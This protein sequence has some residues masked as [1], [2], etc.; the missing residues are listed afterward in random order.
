MLPY[1][2]RYKDSLPAIWRSNGVYQF[3]CGC[4]IGSYKKVKGKGIWKGFHSTKL[5]QQQQE[6]LSLSKTVKDHMLICDTQVAW[7]SE[8]NKF[9]LMLTLFFLMI[10][11]DRPENIRKSLFSAF[12]GI[13]R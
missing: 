3:L 13:K 5:F 12:V 11:F 9:I 8:Y 10:P 1:I 6:N 4:S 7:E 2:L